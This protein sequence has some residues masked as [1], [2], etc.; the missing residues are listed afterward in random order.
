MVD[1]AG[2]EAR[3]SA[4]LERIGKAAERVPAAGAPKAAAEE[5]DK[6]RAALAA[7]KA[8]TEEVERLRAALAAERATSEEVETLR[9]ELEAQKGAAAEAEKLRAE[10]EA[11]K[12]AAAEAETQRAAREAEGGEGEEAE[13]LRTALAAEK[14]ANADLTERVRAIR[15]RQEQMVEGLEKRVVRLQ[16]RVTQQDA[17]LGRLKHANHALRANAEA[18]RKAVADGPV[19]SEM[20][21]AAMEAELEATRAAQAADRSE[22]DAILAELR[23]L[24]EEKADV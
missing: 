16:Q 19:G 13:R 6:L 23:P 10:L 4:A 3:L 11:Q 5:A 2:I 24:I 22:L 17:E 18:I 1:I 12:A 14:S 20:L 9:A 21:N 15:E 7:E 8:A